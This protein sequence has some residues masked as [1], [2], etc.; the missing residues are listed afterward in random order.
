MHSLVDFQRLPKITRRVFQKVA[1]IDTVLTG[2]KN[3]LPRNDF[4][5]DRDRDFSHGTISGSDR[6]LCQAARDGL[7][8]RSRIASLPSGN[9]ENE[10]RYFRPVTSMSKVSE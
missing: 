8:L 9:R 10:T 4:V 6:V 3:T 1:R 7:P 5:D 2:G